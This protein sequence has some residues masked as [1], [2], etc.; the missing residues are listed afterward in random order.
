[1]SSEDGNRQ[2]KELYKTLKNIYEDR[3]E[4]ISLIEECKNEM[5]SNGGHYAMGE[6]MQKYIDKLLKTN[7]QSIKAA[8]ALDKMLKEKE[9]DLPSELTLEDIT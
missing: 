9:D 7:D 4:I 5:S 1:M 8:Q 3:E 2:E 6:V